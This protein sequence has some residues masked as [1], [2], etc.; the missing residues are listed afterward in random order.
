M[1]LDLPGETAHTLNRAEARSL[2][3]TRRRDLDRRQ[4][5]LEMERRAIDGGTAAHE[6]VHQLV[7]GSGLIRHHDD[8]P[9]WLHEGLAAQF[10]VIRGGVWAGVGRV[11]DLRLPDWRAIAPPPPLIPLLRDLGFGH[12]YQR[13]LYAQSWA[14]VYYLRKEHPQQ[15]QT[16]LDLL[17]LPASEAQPDAHRTSAAFRAA[18][19]DDLQTLEVTW[20]RYLARLKTPLEGE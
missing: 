10:E 20:H 13:D 1:R 4:L 15:F 3:E 2:L 9:L 14:L 5:L 17:R 8:F 11:H 12:G 19:G 7:R 18:F 6:M 16:F